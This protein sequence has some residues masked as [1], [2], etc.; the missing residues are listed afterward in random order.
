MEDGAAAG[1]PLV[2]LI[3]WQVWTFVFPYLAIIMVST[4]LIV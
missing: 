3:V 4:S 2:T 1:Q